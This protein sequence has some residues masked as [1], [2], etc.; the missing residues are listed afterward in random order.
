[1]PTATKAEEQ[2]I[3]DHLRKLFKQLDI[4]KF[5]RNKANSAL[6]KIGV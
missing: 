1:M 3:L 2:P 5:N 6:A 4:V